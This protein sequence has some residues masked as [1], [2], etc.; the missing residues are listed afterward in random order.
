MGIWYLG[1]HSRFMLERR[2]MDNL[3]ATAKW[4]L[5]VEWD[6]EGKR[7]VVKADIKAHGHVYHVKLTY[8][9]FFPATPPFVA[10]LDSVA[11]WS[12]HQYASGTL[13]LEWGP[14]NWHPDVTGAQMVESTFRLLDKENPLGESD[15]HDRVLSR[16]F[17]TQG[18]SLRNKIFRVHITK[19]V[20][21]FLSTIEE[22]RIARATLHYVVE[23]NALVYHVLKIGDF[24]NEQL[25]ISFRKSYVKEEWLVYRTSATANQI[26]ELKTIKDLELLIRD[27][28][29][30]T[31]TNSAPE[32]EDKIEGII[33]L[34]QKGEFNFFHFSNDGKLYSVTVVMDDTSTKRTPG[35][36]EGI[37]EKRIAII[38]L[39]SVGSKVADSLCRMGVNKF[40]LVDEDLFLNGNL[41]RH[42]LDWR[43]IGFHKV[44]AIAEKLRY[45]S[46]SI[47]IEVENINLT[48]QESNSYVN[49]VFLKISKCDVIIDATASGQVFNLLASISSSS[50]KPLI[51]GEVYAGGIGGVIARSRPEFDPDPQTMR[52]AYYQFTAETS[53]ADFFAPAPYTLENDE[54]EVLVAS[55][56]DVSVIANHIARLAVDTMLT[57]DDSIFPYSMYLIG[58]AK[59][60]IFSQPF[61]TKPIQTDHLHQNKAADLSDEESKSDNYAFILNLLDK[62]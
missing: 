26:R 31:V 58:L 14:D 41:E 33:L 37:K 32:T 3:Q 59:G 27:Q 7:L 11:R 39:G 54:G 45:I 2:E 42:T 43:N 24:D 35:N 47:D 9:D 29:K 8:S 13:C 38:G 46:P 57:T 52:Q 23:H 10:P 62:Q 5:G 30:Q 48:G 60:W 12:A 25:P 28:D 21:E 61:D 56:A 49:G 50:Q 51:W 1:N 6:L 18:Q 20:I 19:P 55:D 15:R 22:K 17:L 36:L 40:Y 34:N 4:L 53:E 16:H 44:D